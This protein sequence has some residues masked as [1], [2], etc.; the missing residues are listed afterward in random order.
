MVG[1]RPP[2]GVRGACDLLG[3]AP[4]PVQRSSFNPQEP[5]ERATISLNDKGAMKSSVS[6]QRDLG[7]VLDVPPPRPGQVCGLGPV[8]NLIKL[9]FSPWKVEHKE[10]PPYGAVARIK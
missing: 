9:Q 5:L 7:L 6:G 10:W 1:K 4:L 8:I 3:S 2:W